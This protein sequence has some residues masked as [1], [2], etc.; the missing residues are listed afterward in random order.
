MTDSQSALLPSTSSSSLDGKS[1]PLS[2]LAVA[3]RSTA[4]GSP[5]CDDNEKKLI[6][7]LL[8]IK[9]LQTNMFSPDARQ[10]AYHAARQEAERMEMVPQFDEVMS[11]SVNLGSRERNRNPMSRMF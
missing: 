5:S 10:L 7:L 6:A 2:E 8:I 3:A 1:R 11:A 9:N 4:I